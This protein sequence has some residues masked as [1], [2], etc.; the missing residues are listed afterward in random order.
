LSKVAQPAVRFTRADYDRIPEGMHVE[1]I[2]GE[3]L[4]M[5]EPTVRHQEIARRLF[6][7]FLGKLGERRVFFGPLTFAI[8]EH[9]ALVP[10]VLVLRESEI[11]GKDARDIDRAPV[12]AEILSPSTASRDRNVKVGKYLARGVEEVWL[13]DPRSETVEVHARAGTRTASGTE[14][15]PSTA[16][17]DLRLAAAAVFER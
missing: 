10:D 8:D 14:I 17:P 13:L 6:V 5:A 7:L 3:L 15:V 12:I 1:L 16:L 2:D 4:K 9:N 11:P